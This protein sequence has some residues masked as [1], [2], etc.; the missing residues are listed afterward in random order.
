MATKETLEPR[1]ADCSSAADFV[2]LA[3]EALAE[4]ADADY[5]KDL[6]EK[7]E[8]ECQFPG[9]YVAVAE[10]AKEAGL[11]EYAGELY[12]QAEDACFEPSEVS[13]R[14]ARRSILWSLKRAVGGKRPAMTAYFRFSSWKVSIARWSCPR[15]IQWTRVQISSIFSDVIPR[16]PKPITS[17]PRWRAPSAMSS[18]TNWSRPLNAP[19]CSG[20]Q[21]S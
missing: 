1:E 16:T 3:R 4:P 6:L 5:A 19:R 10:A 20:V 17:T 14:S 9:E 21:P 11:E 12:E 13:T 15:P 7:G 18:F 2:A 8:L